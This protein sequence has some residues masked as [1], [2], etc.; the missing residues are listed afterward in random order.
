MNKNSLIV[1]NSNILY[2][3][4]KSS[5]QDN[6]SQNQNNSKNNNK[7][8]NSI[9]NNENINIYKDKFINKTISINET[10]NE[11]NLEFFSNSPI[12]YFF[13]KI[14]LLFEGDILRILIQLGDLY[15]SAIITN[16]YLEIILIQL[17]A[18]AESSLFIKIYSFISSI[19]FC[20]LMKIIVTIAYWDLYQLKWFNLNPFDTITDI[21][22]IKLK[23]YIIRNMYYIINIIFGIIF[24]FFLIGLLTMSYNNGK[25]LDGINL[26]I[27]IIIPFIK[28][29]FIYLTYIYIAIKNLI[30]KDKINNIENNENPFEY[31]MKLNNLIDKGIIKIGNLSHEEKSLNKIDN[32]HIDKIN[33]FE[34]IF[35]KE[36]IFQIKIYKEKIIKFSFKILLKISFTLLSFI[37]IIYLLCDKGATVSSVFFL[38]FVYLISLIISI[39]FSTPSWFINSIYRWY[40]KIR[41]KYDRKHQLKCRLFNE[42]YSPFKVLDSIP[43]IL[44]FILF[45]FFIFMIIRFNISGSHFGTTQTKINQKSEFKVTKWQKEFF[46]E[47]NNIENA[48]CFTKIHG[49]SLLQINSLA[50][51]SYMKD[52]DNITKIY[53]NSFFKE[54]KENITDMKYLDINSKYSVVLMI[55]IDIPNDKPLTVFSIQASI[56]QLDYF[57]DFEMFCNSALFSIIRILTINNLESLTSNA[58]TW[59]LTI[60]IRILEK[61]TLFN[62]YIESLI[63]DIDKEIQIINDKRNII[64]TGHSLG[65]GLAKFLGIKYHKESVS[66]SGPGISSLE[67]KYK[68]DKNYYKYFKSNLIDIV[69]DNDIIPRIENSGGIKYRVICEKDYIFCHQMKRTICQLGAICRREDLT[70]DVCMSIFDRK[71]Y[72]EMRDLA[73][74]KNNIPEDYND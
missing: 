45:I 61:F 47:K 39:Q 9:N 65:G 20:C 5:E 52:L 23:K 24:W 57:L 22:N 33:F 3:N 29:L 46:S 49:L 25:L 56:K 43:L 28:F 10:E 62:K 42:K 32:D 37:Y 50:F 70:G 21:L 60:P 18:S 74:I 73:G 27:F 19:I 71:E 36:I 63:N 58:I 16:I 55:N 51:A 1:L 7:M 48:I 12:I 38:V 59:F 17:C 13:L 66:I 34:K 40:L 26:V 2:S 4:F 44:S 14:F 69:P 31:W 6:I 64:F 11:K 67:Y 53:E 15:F 68:N 54:K 8:N 41:K 30:Y 35:C 72:E